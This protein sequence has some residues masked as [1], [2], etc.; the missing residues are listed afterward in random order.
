MP[1]G[2]KG[3]Q[4][5]ELNPMKLPKNRERAKLWR[6][7]QR[8]EKH[9]NWQGGIAK[10]NHQIRHKIR[11]LRKLENIAGRKKSNQCE[12]C[13][14]TKKICFDHCHKTGRFRGWICK[15]C[16]TTLGLVKDNKKLLNLIIKYLQKL[17]H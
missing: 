6:Q 12:I 5:G 11:Y 3:F 1:K 17:E 16:N 10:K 2:L 14:S 15:R 13:N 9:W 8:G 7:N 4:V